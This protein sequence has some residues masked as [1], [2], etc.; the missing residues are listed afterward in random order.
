MAPA[1]CGT[2]TLHI[3]VH[4][5]DERKFAAAEALGYRPVN[6]FEDGLGYETASC[7]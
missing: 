5:I 2:T 3:N 6:S 7:D 4:G 1:L